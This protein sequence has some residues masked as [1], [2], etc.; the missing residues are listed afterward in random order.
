MGIST[1]QLSREQAR[2]CTD[3]SW[4]TPQRLT[5]TLGPVFR[6]APE[7][8]CSALSCSAAAPKRCVRKRATPPV[9]FPAPLTTSPLESGRPG[10]S[11]PGTFR[12]WAFSPFDGLL[13]QRFACLISYRRRL[14][15][16]KSWNGT[17][18]E[19][20]TTHAGNLP[21]EDTRPIAEPRAPPND[22]SR[23]NGS[24]AC[25]DGRPLSQTQT[26]A[27][28]PTRHSPRSARTK[29]TG[30][31]RVNSRSSSGPTVAR[32]RVS[33][34]LQ[35]EPSCPIPDVADKPEGLPATPLRHAHDWTSPRTPHAPESTNGFPGSPV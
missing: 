18:G 11:T 31:G 25:N 22:R 9:R 33:P 7:P 30:G 6:A 4:A 13:L 17:A 24:S 28:T 12:P 16:S 15:G 29:T 32:D 3:P 27:A 20:T 10:I 19:S 1:G 14:W 34:R 26:L 2:E 21:K 8:L 23:P 5:R 35:P